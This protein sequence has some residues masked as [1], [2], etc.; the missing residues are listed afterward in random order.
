MHANTELV[1][2]KPN[3]AVIRRDAHDRR[4]ENKS[5]FHD[6]ACENSPPPTSSM[7]PYG[8]T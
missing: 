7:T 5:C 1:T 4:N 2:Y 8:I 3:N 6:T